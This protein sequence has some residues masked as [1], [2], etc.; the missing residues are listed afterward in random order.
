MAVDDSPEL[1]ESLVIIG[2]RV[3]N[4]FA[5]LD[6]L[7][8]VD[9]GDKDNFTNELQRFELWATSLGLYH[10]S[11]FSNYYSPDTRLTFFT[12]R[13][14]LGDALV[15]SAQETRPE[16]D[17]NIAKSDCS[18]DSEE[19]DFSSY[20]SEP[21][22][23]AYLG[24][25]TVTIDRLYRLS[26]KIRNPAMRTGLSKA[27][28]YTEVDPDTGVNL[29]EVYASLDLS[30]LVELFRCFGHRHPDDLKDHYLVQRLAR[31]NTRRRQQFR[32][33]R[34]RKVK[35]E[36]YS[37]ST[38]MTLKT[39][40]NS[41][42]HLERERR[43]IH[44]PPSALS[45]PSTATM[46]NVAR[47]KL[48]D[49][50]SIISTQ[51]CLILA[52]DKSS[53]HISIPPPPAT[54]SNAK[55]F[56]C[57]YC[58]TICPRKFIT[59]EAWETHI[60]RDLRPYVCTFEDCKEPDQQYDTLSDWMS[61][62]ASKHNVI[63]DPDNDHRAYIRNC[64]LCLSPNASPVHI[65]GHLRRIACFSLP[66]SSSGRD[67]STLG[68]GLSDRPEI[69]SYS[70]ERSSMESFSW[71]AWS[72]NVSTSREPHQSK[73][74]VSEIDVA[75]ENTTEQIQGSCEERTDSPVGK[76]V[77]GDPTMVPLSTPS[78][79]SPIRPILAPE[80]RLGFLLADRLELTS[81][82][83]NGADGVVYKGIDI[84]T[85]VVYAVKALN[86]VGLDAR[87][88]QFQ[89]RE[90]RLH[91]RV[92]EHPNVVSLV[93]IMDSVDCTYMV[94]EFCPEG[95]LF[96]SITEEGNFV[97]ND[98]LAKRVFLQMLDAVHYCHS[99]GVYH[100]NLNPENIW[101][102][103]QGLTVKLAGFNLATT[104][105]FTA[106]FGC[107][108]TFY[109]SPE[110]QQSNPRP[111]SCY[112]SA[113]NDVWS[114]GVIL[115]NLTCGRNPFKRA[116]IEDSTYRAYRKDPFFLKSILPLSEELVGI[117]SRVFECEPTKRITIPELRSLILDC[118]VFT[119]KSYTSDDHSKDQVG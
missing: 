24:N 64:P 59:K 66:K 47:V 6:G 81:I 46:L 50:A 28:E 114:L 87:Q 103:G 118:P 80:D 79:S 27:L 21:V 77:T 22:T 52:G 111:M 67:E 11:A 15:A 84:H 16:D 98:P 36:E 71:E 3:S 107:G 94:M 38:E 96:S 17:K 91:H 86:K 55:E 44:G 13:G 19:E 116:S 49:E 105:D 5:A 54:D 37:K 108:S 90:I 41:N 20:Q 43:V 68:S 78:P 63:S 89:Q 70:S 51:S 85:N 101:V 106:D 34:K 30:H 88:L 112:A 32:Y 8:D 2:I 14:A 83:A 12:V 110:C 115:V 26:F 92:S 95:D 48:E 33:W 42:I 109:M 99:L 25:I 97:G 100:R 73:T 18:D 60:F 53:D 9:G 10:A 29:I 104:D 45:Q 1:I 117:L 62:E 7:I 119:V 31:A 75:L 39:S 82:L 23:K 57:P 56:E 72:E 113:P 4:Q 65:A 58:F 61:H 102:T 69:V 74:D 76:H 40:Q 93:N 35:Y